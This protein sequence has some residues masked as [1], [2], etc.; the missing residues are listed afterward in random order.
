M[1]APMAR[2]TILVPRGAEAAAVRRARTSARVVEVPAG[3]AAASALPEFDDGETVVAL[4]LCGALRR[5]RAG[6]VV[7]YRRVAEDVAVHGRVADDATAHGCAGTPADAQALDA[8]LIDTMIAALPG[9]T[10]VN[11]CSAERVV[12]IIAARTILAQRFD[13]DVVDMEGA[14]LAAALRARGVR[15]VMVR[16]VSDDVSRDLPPIEDAFDAEGRLQ[17]LR[18]AIAFARAPRAAF[19]F[20]RDV[21]RALRVL[22]AT[23]RAIGLRTE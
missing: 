20:V 7:I 2:M 5:L 16:V 15:F 18:I 12:T 4:G 11:A 17:P 22:R 9:A 13:A 6:D 14:N 23:A 1:R 8:G 10:V 3:K 19:A 21:R